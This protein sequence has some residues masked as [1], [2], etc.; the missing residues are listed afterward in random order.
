MSLRPMA[1][2]MLRLAH[3]HPGIT[4]A[5][6]ARRLGIGSGAASDLAASLL[7]TGL[8]AERPTQAAGRGRPT[9][10][11]VA[12]PRGPLVLAV[13]IRHGSW[14]LDAFAL[15]DRRLAS[16]SGRHHGDSQ[17]RAVP[18]IATAV[19]AMRRRFPG[20]VRGLG[21]SGAGT[22]REGRWLDATTFGWRGVDLRRIWPRAPLF[23]AGNDATLAAIAEGL[24]GTARTSDLTVHLHIDVGLGGAVL[25]AGA[26]V[27]GAHRLAGEFGHMPMGD[28]RIHCPCGAR[29]CWGA[30]LDGTYL[31][32]LLDDPPPTDPVGYAQRVLER[33]HAGDRAARAAARRVA[34]TLGRGTAGLVNALDAD[35]VVLGGLAP[36]IVKAA[37]AGFDSSYRD[38][39]MAARREIPTPVQHAVLG[40]EG[41]LI[42]AAETVW[43][44]LWRQLSAETR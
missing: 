29:G 32:F 6:A 21:V 25:Q 35:L 9:R 30:S 20:R 5:E 4:R 1:M 42:G 11:F 16:V 19:T 12:A 43:P 41:P 26:V 27:E 18:A 40:E 23:A 22:V 15:G 44:L 17:A 34:R 13:A 37:P 8:L 38:G 14:R 33:A 2:E 3:L 28:Q 24:R 39:L 7:G 36:D 10:E 31:A